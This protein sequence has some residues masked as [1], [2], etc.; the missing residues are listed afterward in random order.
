MTPDQVSFLAAALGLAVGPVFALGTRPA[1]VAGGLLFQFAFIV[2]C[3][4]GKL[5]RALGTT[6]DKGAALDIFGDSIRRASSSLGLIVGIWRA[7]G[8]GTEFWLAIIY[9]ALAYFFIE[10]SGGSE[11]RQE[12]WF[13]KTE[14]PGT[15]RREGRLGAALARRRLLPTPGMPD[16]QALVFVVGPVTSLLTPSLAVGAVMVAGGALISLRRK[17]R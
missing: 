3:I 11:V 5:A 9:V 6:S 14:Q 1:F 4:D 8:D 17:L 2:D 16:V 10:L 7:E 13:K 12:A 15:E